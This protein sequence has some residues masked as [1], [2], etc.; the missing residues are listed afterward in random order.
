MLNTQSFVARNPL[1]Q[2]TQMVIFLLD[3]LLYCICGNTAH[4]VFE[5]PSNNNNLT[6]GYSRQLNDTEQWYTCT[7]LPVFII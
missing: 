6:A 2:Q 5:V 3:L 4:T 7:R 1:P